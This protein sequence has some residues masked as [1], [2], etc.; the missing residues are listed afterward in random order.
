MNMRTLAA[1]IALSAAGLL[2]VAGCG[3]DSSDDSSPETTQAASSS[4]TSGSNAEVVKFDKT[5]QQ[6]LKDVGCYSGQVDGILGPETDAAVLAFQTAEGLD[7]DGEVGPETESALDEAVSK[8][9]TVCGTSSSTTATTSTTTPAT[10]PCTAAAVGAALPSGTEIGTY[11]CSEGYAGVS[12]TAS[13]GDAYHA[14]LEADGS[15]WKN[16][17][18][19]PCGS[20]SAGISPQVLETGCSSS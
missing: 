11:V 5:I 12:G 15:S 20:A 7:A 3:S 16:L 18:E 4:T 8:G 6:Q 19:E 17:G 13:G 14:V 10:A 9:D 1:G 2:V